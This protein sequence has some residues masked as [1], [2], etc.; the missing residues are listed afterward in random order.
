MTEA[1]IMTVESVRSRASTSEALVTFSVPL[2]KAAAV[3]SFMNRI[4]RQVGAAFADVNDVPTAPAPEKPKPKYGAYA[5]AL[6]LSGFCRAPDVWRAAG[7]DEAF[8]AWIQTKPSWHS[9]NFSEYVDGVGRCVAAH[10]R[11]VADGAGTGHKPDY[12]CVPLT[13][14]EH[15]LQH[16]RGES[17]LAPESEWDKARIT[18]VE[19]WCWD[20]IKSQLGETTMAAVEPNALLE[21]AKLHGVETYLP[22]C[23]RTGEAP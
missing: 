20:T 17:A 15:Q 7:T 18:Y 19:D 14:A 4:G 5:K 6:R 21:W 13:D 1:L 16:Q 3:S 10:V 8:R 12:A 11:R 2:E 22:P 23:Y 9:G